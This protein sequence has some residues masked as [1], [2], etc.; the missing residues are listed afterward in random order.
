M[1]IRSRLRTWLRG[2][3]HREEL[4]RQISE[5]LQFHLESYAEDLM[6]SG[7]SREEAMRRA[8]AEFGIEVYGT[9]ALHVLR[10]EKG[11]IVIG[12][13]TDG[14]VTPG[15]VG[16]DGLVS[17]KKAD[18]IGK[19]SLALPE[20]VRPDRLQLVGLEGT[21]GAQMHP[22]SHVRLPDS[23]QPTDGW[24]TS[25]GNASL[26][27]TPIALAMLRGGRSRTGTV[28]IERVIAVRSVILPA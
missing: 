11:Y 15:D 14:T 23:T 4:D 8:R 18:F 9:E 7:I 5:E 22:G 10:A 3:F 16:L 2:V 25:A 20:N 26:S 13:E 19:R 27:G 28:L 24:V 17:K 12:D 6:S 1:S 21:D